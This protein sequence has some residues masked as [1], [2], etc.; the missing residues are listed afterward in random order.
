VSDEPYTET[1]RDS[2]GDEIVE[3]MQRMTT[4]KASL[5]V[6]GRILPIVF[7]NV[8]ALVNL[9]CAMCGTKYE[10]VMGCILYA[11]LA[12]FQRVQARKAA[13]QS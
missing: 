7:K 6:A 13:R 4:D 9:S 5:L 8:Q 2:D 12:S 10:V 11:M 3:A 1:Q